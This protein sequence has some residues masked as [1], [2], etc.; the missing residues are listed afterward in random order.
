MM[1]DL[2]Q[3]MEVE[4][5]LLPAGLLYSDKEVRSYAGYYITNDLK[6]GFDVSQTF[7]SAGKM[8]RQLKNIF[9]MSQQTIG[10][11]KVSQSE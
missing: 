10:T 6:V 3:K 7:D 5:T 9:G 8:V 2:P 1:S 4:V 11:C